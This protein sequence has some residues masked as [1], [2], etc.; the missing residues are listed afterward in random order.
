MGTE[1]VGKRMGFHLSGS[2]RLIL[3]TVS[4]IVNLKFIN[5]SI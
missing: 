1:H 3:E 4:F 5:L 2:S